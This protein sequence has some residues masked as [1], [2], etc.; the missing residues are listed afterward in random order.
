[1][2]TGRSASLIERAAQYLPTGVTSAAR[3]SA[4]PQL[5]I[6]S[7]EGARVHDADGN[8]FIDYIMGF[9]PLLLGHAPQRI[10]DAIR[11]QLSRG[12]LYGAAH[13]GEAA[14]SEALASIM[15]VTDKVIFSNTGSEAVHI[16]LRLARA[17]TGRKI[18]VKFEGHYHGWFDSVAYVGV[19]A[20]FPLRD[21]R[22]VSLGLAP[23]NPEVLVLP[24]NDVDA[25]TEVF[26]QFPD[27]I[28]AVIMEPVPQMGAI[29]PASNYPQAVRD[30]TRKHG[31]ALVYDEVVTGFRAGLGGMHTVQGVRPDL[32][33][34]GKALGAGMPI[35]AVIGSERYFEAVELGTAPHMGTFNGHAL[36][37]AAATA[38]VDAYRSDGFYDKLH[39]RTS[40][41]AEAIDL[42]AR[43]HGIP[44]RVAQNGALISLVGQSPELPVSTFAD[45][46]SHDAKLISNLAEHL[47]R[48]GVLIQ[49]R[50]VLMVSSTHDDAIIDESIERFGRAFARLAD[51]FEG[52]VE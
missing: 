23:T 29:Q 28:A 47:A 15:P 42:H 17:K 6:E 19:G 32:V 31:A 41:L 4:R 24:W 9:G 51:A 49:A 36:A 39:G 14:L 13:R 3:A 38:A 52:T 18:I 20:G 50:G 27:Q 12:F 40:R 7:G 26:S 37:T 10:D 44:I 48:A 33:V 25:L 8:R 43:A 5:V 46:A 21:Q 34:L 35:S 45:I 22:A 2:H 16:A 1:M 11:E 30:L